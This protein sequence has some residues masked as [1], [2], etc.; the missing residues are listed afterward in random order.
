[1]INNIQNNYESS[2][3][4]G[5]NGNHYNCTFNPLDELIKALNANKE[6]Y[7]RLL[8]SEH[9]KVEILKNK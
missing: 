6:L 7:K 3:N 8:A 5:S 4:H 1:V 9:E 2:N